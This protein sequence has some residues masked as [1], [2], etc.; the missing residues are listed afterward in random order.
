MRLSEHF[1]HIK[2]NLRA[3]IQKGMERPLRETA[4]IYAALGAISVGGLAMA[5]EIKEDREN[6]QNC[7][8]AADISSTNV[9]C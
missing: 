3:D 2:E 5:H 7:P 6:S 8:P 9:E 1:T 4:V